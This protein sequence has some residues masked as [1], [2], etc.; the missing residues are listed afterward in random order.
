MPNI[1]EVHSKPGAHEPGDGLLSKPRLHV[2]VCQPII[3]QNLLAYISTSRASLLQGSLRSWRC[4][5]RTRNKVLAAPTIT[6]EPPEASGDL[7]RA[8]LQYRQ[9]RRLSIF[10]ASTDQYLIQEK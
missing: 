9:L 8:R 2:S 1:K 6:S 3:W 7:F 5:K 4:C 10:R